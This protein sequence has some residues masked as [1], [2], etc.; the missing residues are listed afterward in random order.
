[1]TFG[2]GIKQIR[3][4]KGISQR[5]LGIRLGVTQQTVARYE[6]IKEPPKLATIRKIAKALNLSFDDCFKLWLQEK[7][8]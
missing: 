1:M 5:E 7:E 4:N 3:K 2:E 6:K 8:E